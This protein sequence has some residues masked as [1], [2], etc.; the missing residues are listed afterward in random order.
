M[1]RLPFPFAVNEKVGEKQGAKQEKKTPGTK[2]LII[3]KLEK[4]EKQPHHITSPFGTPGFNPNITGNLMNFY[5][6]TLLL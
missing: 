4:E 2:H 3:T 6:K 1:K 5:N